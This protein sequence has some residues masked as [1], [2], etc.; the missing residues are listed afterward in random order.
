M[1]RALDAYTAGDIEGMLSSSIR[2]LSSI[3]RSSAGPRARRI[4][5][6]RHWSWVAE[7]QASLSRWAWSR[8]RLRDLGDRVLAFG[9]VHAKGRESCVALARPRAG[10]SPLRRQDP[11]GPRLPGP[12]E[13]SRGRWAG[14]VARSMR[15]PIVGS[16]AG[17]G[18]RQEK[19]V[20]S[21][22]PR[23][24]RTRGST[25]GSRVEA[26]GRLLAG[27]LADVADAAR[28]RDCSMKISHAQRPIGPV[29]QVQ[30]HR[31]LPREPVDRLQVEV[32]PKSLTAT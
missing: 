19:I 15:A 17:R 25:P 18:R 31:N 11:P 10:S 6:M 29:D 12:R 24:A 27:A 7:T 4:R 26:A 8:P 2:M 5:A 23:C 20:A 13:G 3:R 9:R 16:T 22:W 21:P 30:V 32:E 1:R 28:G 14:G